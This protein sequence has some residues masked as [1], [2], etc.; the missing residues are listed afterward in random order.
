MSDTIQSPKEKKS[1]KSYFTAFSRKFS[2]KTVTS[3]QHLARSVTVS[4]SKST[5]S[6]RKH[7]NTTTTTTST[8]IASVFIPRRQ[9]A[10]VNG[11]PAPRL[12]N[13]VYRSPDA[14]FIE[15]HM[16]AKIRSIGA[17]NESGK[18]E[19]KEEVKEK[20]DRMEGYTIRIIDPSSNNET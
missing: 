19:E 4:R 3:A 15:S 7:S 9:S 18:G 20:K 12:P 8:S 13:I 16:E 5:K 6:S 2:Q 17:S 1:L 14:D 11:T 10:Q